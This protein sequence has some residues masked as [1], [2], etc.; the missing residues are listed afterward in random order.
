MMIKHMGLVDWLMIIIVLILT[1]ENLFQYNI[2]NKIGADCRYI[3]IGYDR[4][5]MYDPTVRKYTKINGYYETGE[6]F[7]VWTE[8]RTDEEIN[9]TFCHESCHDFVYK[10]REHFCGKEP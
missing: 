7:C 1:I 2:I 6:F 10:R 9:N 8:G 4:G 3:M 5:K